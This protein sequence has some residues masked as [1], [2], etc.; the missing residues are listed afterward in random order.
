MAWLTFLLVAVVALVA[1]SVISSRMTDANLRRLVTY[2]IC[3]RILG[4]F[5]RYQVMEVAYSGVGDAKMY[6]EYGKLLAASITSFDFGFLVDG[7]DGTGRLYG[8]SFIEIVTS[9]AALFVGDS[10]PAAFLVFSLVSFSGLVLCVLAFREAFEKS[11]A[12]YAAWVW[13]LPSLWFWPSSVGKE[14]LMIPALGLVLWGY[15]GKHGAPRW[16]ALGLGVA[17]AAAIRPHVGAV[18]GFSVAVGEMLRRGG[19]KRARRWLN[20]A[21]S[22]VLVIM[23]IRFGI[24]EMGLGDADLEGLEE[25]FQFRAGHT[26]QGGSRIE[27]ASGLTAIPFAFVNIL[28]RPFPWEAKGISAF[29]AAELWLF[30]AVV[31]RRRKDIRRGLADWRQNRFFVVAAPFAIAMTLL[32]GLAFANLGIIARQRVVLLPLLAALVATPSREREQI[33][34]A[35]IRRPAVGA[36]TAS[37]TLEEQA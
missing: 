17:L 21:V 4:S 28:F 24:S 26:E 10:L 27:R 14:A 23:T 12:T 9:V 5:A 13:L 15:V 33:A 32:Y 6:F 11:P 31:F 25:Q 30:W 22:A 18:F 3:A 1:G 34:R 8:T 29:S 36:R 19:K 20:I 7:P 35:G 16:V 2:G 37:P